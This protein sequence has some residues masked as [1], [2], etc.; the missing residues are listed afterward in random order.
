MCTDCPAFAGFIPGDLITKFGFQTASAPDH[1]LEYRFQEQ[2]RSLLLVNG[3]LRAVCL[4]DLLIPV[5]RILHDPLLGCK[6]YMHN[7][8]ALC[9][10]LVPLKVVQKC[11]EEIAPHIHAFIIRLL[12]CR[13]V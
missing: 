8:K 1:L 13:N 5:R 6:I 11:P 12:E 10:S 9:I 4:N 7:S 2:N 3:K